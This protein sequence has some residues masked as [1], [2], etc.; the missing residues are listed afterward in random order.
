MMGVACITIGLGTIIPGYSDLFLKIRLGLRQAI[1]IF[2]PIQ[3]T[4]LPSSETR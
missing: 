4:L 2:M 1:L 3:E